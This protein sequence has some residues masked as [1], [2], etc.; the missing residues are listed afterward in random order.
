[1]LEIIAHDCYYALE[2]FHDL[3]KVNMSCYMAV[4]T[5]I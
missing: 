4:Q 1:M 3:N 5:D 2:D